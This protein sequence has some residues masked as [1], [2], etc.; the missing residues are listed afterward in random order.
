[1]LE[2]INIPGYVIFAA[3]GFFCGWCFRDIG[4][5]KVLAIF[6]IVPSMFQFVATIDEML[7]VTLPFIVGCV[8]GFFGLQRSKYKLLNASDSLRDFIGRFR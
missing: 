3:V 4:I 5:L 6:L 2:G 7:W 8:L 1:M